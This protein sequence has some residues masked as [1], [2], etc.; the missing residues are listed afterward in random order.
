MVGMA[1][2]TALGMSQP[3]I[4]YAVV[5]LGNIA[6]IAVLPAF[7]HAPNSKLSALVSGNPH[8]LKLLGERYGVKNLYSY[9]EY[10]KC[11]SSGEIDAVYIALPNHLH[12]EY[13]VR[14]A[15]AGIHVLCEKP[16]AVS[17]E[18][19]EAMIRAANEN[20]VKLMIAYRLHFEE[21]NL[22][23]IEIVKSGEIGDPKIFNSVFITPI[24]ELSNIRLNPSSLGGG[25]L[26]DIGI[27]CINAARHLFR[28]EPNEVLGVAL[29]SGNF[30]ARS[31]DET[32][33]SLLRFDDDK[34]GSFVC[35]YGCAEAN[36]YQI[37]G[38]RGTLI[39]ENSY[40]FY[41]DITH[42]LTVNEKT[43]SHTYEKRDQ[44]APELITLSDCILNNKEPEP[45]GAEGLA[46]VRVIE[47]ILRST[48]ASL[49]VP[50]AAF[51]RRVQ[52]SI[53]QNIYCPPF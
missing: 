51:A 4:R 30:N 8:K 25:P 41:G 12:K 40:T 28:A 14:A 10:D 17:S 29:N 47:A 50:L 27:Y 52:P 31:T 39:V 9:S 46:D 24:K 13:S 7:A 34:A 32:V 42:R 49:P 22:R 33:Y 16:M 36:H 11:L 2:A 1:P 43:V 5:G 26:Y 15:N 18:D 53:E 21:A 44:F 6:Q 37:I 23:A 35:S 45:S 3:Q 38:T 48:V 20:R 19:C